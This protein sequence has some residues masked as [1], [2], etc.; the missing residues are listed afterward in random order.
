MGR[1]PSQNRARARRVVVRPAVF[2][3]TPTSVRREVVSCITDRRSSTLTSQRIESKPLVF[4]ACLMPLDKIRNWRQMHSRCNVSSL[5]MSLIGCRAWKEGGS[6]KKKNDQFY[7]CIRSGLN[8]A[9]VVRRQRSSSLI[10]LAVIPPCVDHSE[11]SHAH[12]TGCRRATQPVFFSFSL[13]TLSR[14]TF[15][16]KRRRDAAE[17]R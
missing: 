2:E 9:N 4:G 17:V 15:E 10:M 11:I 7:S 16:N 12:E 3:R 5:V 1:Q 13:S 6:E 14:K 8:A